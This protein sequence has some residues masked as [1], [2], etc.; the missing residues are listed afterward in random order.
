M[1]SEQQKIE[2]RRHLGYPVVGNPLVSPSGGTLASGFI[3]WRFHQVYGLLEWRMNNLQPFEEAI[4]FGLATAGIVVQSAAA[5][6]GQADVPD[7]LIV[8]LEIKQPSTGVA[9]ID[10]IITYITGA[11]E[12]IFSVGAAF[13][14]GILANGILVGAGFWA[15]SPFKPSS[16]TPP[17]PGIQ[18]I[19]SSGSF[20]VIPVNS[21]PLF[22]AVQPGSGQF[23]NPI[24]TFGDPAATIRGYI[25][26]LDALETQIAQASDNLDTTKA[27]VWTAREDEVQIREHLYDRWRRKVAQFLALPLWEDTEYDVTRSGAS[28]RGMMVA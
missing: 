27:D 17:F 21:A 5:P 9:V 6:G 18:I 20:I 19:C 12:T 11:N 28:G 16:N 14:A 10:E 8:S 13:A 26:I 3:G 25:P 15:V 1:L 22:L 4:L 23:M 7:G 2:I 24:A